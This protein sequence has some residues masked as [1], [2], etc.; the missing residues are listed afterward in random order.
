[1]NVDALGENN[2][3]D[4]IK[5]DTE[6]SVLMRLKGTSASNDPSTQL[7]PSTSKGT[8]TPSLPLHSNLFEAIIPGRAQDAATA[9]RIRTCG[10]LMWFRSNLFGPAE[11]PP[12]DAVT[13]IQTCFLVAWYP[14]IIAGSLIHEVRK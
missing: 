13:V 7:S 8:T 3:W 14:Y 6:N 12:A 4:T 2:T 9:E 1:M 11:D 10:V 5:L